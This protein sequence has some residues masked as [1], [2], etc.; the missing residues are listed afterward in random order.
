MAIESG[1]TLATML[2]NWES[3][4]LASCFQ[5]YRDIRKPRT[6]KQT[7]TSYEAGK[8]ASAD[9]P[10]SFTETFRPDLLK[11]RMR[12]IM[13]KD[14]LAEVSER[15]APFF[16]KQNTSAAPENKVQIQASL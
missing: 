8:L 1:I 2:R 16:S 15:C 10:D 11:E 7:R 6:D 13:E 3:N 5:L 4:D 14:V 12:W 9:L